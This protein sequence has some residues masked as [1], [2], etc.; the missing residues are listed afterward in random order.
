MPAPLG[1]RVFRIRLPDL[2]LRLGLLGTDAS[3]DDVSALRAALALVDP[4]VL[5]ARV[6]EIAAVDVRA[7]LAGRGKAHVYAERRQR[8]AW[9]GARREC[10]GHTR[11]TSNKA[12]QF[13]GGVMHARELFPGLLERGAER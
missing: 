13:G 5:A 7:E 2:A 4:S 8:T 6:R 10:I 9:R 3:Q 12:M 11:P 1:K